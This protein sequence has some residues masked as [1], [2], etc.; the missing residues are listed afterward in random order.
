MRVPLELDV[1]RDRNRL[2]REHWDG[3]VENAYTLRIM[4]MEQRD[5]TYRVRWDADIETRLSGK[6]LIEVPAGEQ[7]S[8]PFSLFASD[9]EHGKPNVDVRFTIETVDE[10]SYSVTEVSRFL[11]PDRS[12]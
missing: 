5:R 1:I 12:G 6:E 8:L 11:R 4:N 9:A 2:Y 7:R 3:T 10:P